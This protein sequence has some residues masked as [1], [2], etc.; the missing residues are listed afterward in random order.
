MN[1]S[2]N[3]TVSAF[4]R[5]VAEIAKKS[6]RIIF[7]S[8]SLKIDLN[9]AISGNEKSMYVFISYMCYFLLLYY[10]YTTIDINED[11]INYKFLFDVKSYQ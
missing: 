10:Y 1:L 9:Q 2:C 3:R 4:K 6:I 7:E 11:G 5:E 8:Y